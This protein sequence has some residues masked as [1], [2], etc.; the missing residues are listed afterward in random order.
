[1]ALILRYVDVRGEGFDL[2]CWSA[3]FRRPTAT[4]YREERKKKKKKI[5]EGFW[6]LGR[7]SNVLA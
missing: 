3:M 1:M 6:G 5:K 7:L 4:D 2:V